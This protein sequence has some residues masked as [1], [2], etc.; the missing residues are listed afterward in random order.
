MTLFQTFA[1]ALAVH[2]VTPIPLVFLA[3][4][5][6]GALPAAIK[7]PDAATDGLV[8]VLLFAA[9]LTAG[10]ALERAPHP[11]VL[12]VV[13]GGA[14]LATATAV[15]VFLIFR[16]AGGFGIASSTAV[17]AHYASISSVA[18]LA[19]LATF[20]WPDGVV[21]LGAAVMS[22][23]AAVALLVARVAVGQVRGNFGDAALFAQV[24]RGRTAVLLIAGVVVG[25]LVPE[26]GRKAIEPLI[27][28]FF[29]P[30]VALLML[31]AGMAAARQMRKLGEA[32][33]FATVFAVLWPFLAGSAGVAAAVWLGLSGP[34]AVAFGA[35]AAGASTVEATRLC[36]KALVQ[37]NPGFYRTAALAVTLPLTVL[38]GLPWFMALA[39]ALTRG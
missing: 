32:G 8:M 38:V 27:G 36:E 17:A 15:V 35:L 19:A 28:T 9:G 16:M 22:W 31:P 21:V 30:L 20:P 2:L 29:M 18:L 7:V 26:A 23:G 3:G 4:L 34:G 10:M 37:A 11:G 25:V 33:V 12:A 24:F 5:A 14:A 6:A 13:A 39:A 1:D